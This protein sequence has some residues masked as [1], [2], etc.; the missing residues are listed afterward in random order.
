G[1]QRRKPK[2]VMGG[3]E[4]F[5]GWK[6]LIKE[7]KKRLGRGLGGAD[8]EA[9]RLIHDNDIEGLRELLAEHPALLSW[10]ADENDGGLLGMATGSFGDS[11]DPFSEEHFTRAACAE[12]LID[13][14]AVVAPA[15]CDGL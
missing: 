3:N 11:F 8:S 14:G 5:Q 7:V 13:A 15:V 1:W 6:D 10:R 9:R 2:V 12:L 4:G